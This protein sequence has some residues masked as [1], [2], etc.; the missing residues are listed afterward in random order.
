M[1][2]IDANVLAGSLGIVDELLG[3]I[4]ADGYDSIGQRICAR[5]HT[6]CTTGHDE[7]GVIGGHAAVGID[8]I[9][10]HA[11]G[12]AQDS[13]EGRRIG[14]GISGEDDEHR[15]ESRS[16]H[17]GTLGHAAHSE[18]VAVRHGGLG[19]GVGGHDGNRRIGPTVGM[20]RRRCRGDSREEP[21]HQESLADEAGR[22]H[23]HLAR[24]RAK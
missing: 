13:V 20:E 11:G 4:G 2:N 6:G 8:A 17:S 22:A 9:E 7:N 24:T 19:D 14:A 10:G 21:I 1:P 18:A 15:R 16:Q 23:G 3:E 12:L 5:R